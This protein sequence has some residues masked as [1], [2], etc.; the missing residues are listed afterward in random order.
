MH[1]KLENEEIDNIVPT[2]SIEDKI[3]EA[4]IPHSSEEVHNITNINENEIGTP[5]LDNSVLNK[6]MLNLLI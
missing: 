5:L 3:D 6:S 2:D 4:K 1:V